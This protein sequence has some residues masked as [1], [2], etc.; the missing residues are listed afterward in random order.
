MITVPSSTT[1]TRSPG[2]AAASPADDLVRQLYGLGALRRALL[3]AA[4]DEI[5]ANGFTALA[6]IHRLEPCRV[7]DIAQALH[8]D[9]SV[10]SR[11]ITALVRAGHAAREVDPVDRRA[12]RVR[13][14]SAG[15]AVL[16][17]GHRRMVIELERAIED[18][19]EAEVL[20]LAAGIRRLAGRFA[21]QAQDA[22]TTEEHA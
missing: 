8:V 22:E 12:Q 1:A 19:D 5:A 21:E 18:W 17:D 20:Q 4:T 2:Q 14:T 13:L 10:A 15:Q 11:Q 3:R 16:T 6:A 7:S 9:L